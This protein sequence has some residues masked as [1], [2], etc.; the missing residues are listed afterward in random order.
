MKTLSILFTL[1]LFVTAN[2][3]AAHLRHAHALPAHTTQLSSIHSQNIQT[4][5]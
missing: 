2:A 1:V 4:N 5:Q 3:L